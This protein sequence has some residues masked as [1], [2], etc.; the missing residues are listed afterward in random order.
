[1]KMEIVFFQT[2]VENPPEPQAAST[3]RENVDSSPNV[4]P[5][6]TSLN[7]S[8][9][10]PVRKEGPTFPSRNP[11]QWYLGGFFSSIFKKLDSG[12]SNR[13]KTSDNRK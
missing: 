7:S 11:D 13:R 9:V 3:A 10:A 12:S 1:M 8:D 2:A 4:K 5:M 6:S